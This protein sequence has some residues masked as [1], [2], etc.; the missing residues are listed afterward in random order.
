MEHRFSLVKFGIVF[1]LIIVC[2]S[3]FFILIFT[4]IVLRIDSELPIAEESDETNSTHWVVF[5]ELIPCLH[6]RS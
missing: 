3:H 5:D 4:S 2:V 6:D 1:V